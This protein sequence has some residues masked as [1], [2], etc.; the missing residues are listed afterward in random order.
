MLRID[1]LP[2]EGGEVARNSLV[3]LLPKEGRGDS[4]RAR[5]ATRGMAFA[6]GR[7]WA[8]S[9]ER[10]D[11][12]DALRARCARPLQIIRPDTAECIH[13][14]MC[15]LDELRETIPAQRLGLGMRGGGFHGRKRGEIRAQPNGEV[16]FLRAVA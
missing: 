1:P 4:E 10:A 13:R 16:Q 5:S 15:V 14:Q 2:A 3:F 9:P 6:C 11:T 7:G 12:R 8:Q